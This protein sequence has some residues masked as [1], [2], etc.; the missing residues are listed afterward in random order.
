VIEK[1]KFPLLKEYRINKI[2][3]CLEC[4]EKYPYNRFMQKKCVI[5]KYNVKDNKP[6]ERLEKSIFRGMVLTS[7]RILGFIYGESNFLRLSSNGQLLLEG[8]RKNSNIF[9]YIKQKLILE[10]DEEKFGFLSFFLNNFKV[11]ELKKFL[12]FFYPK[13]NAISIKQKKERIMKWL[14]ILKQVKLIYY[15]EEKIYL[16]EQNYYFMISYINSKINTEIFKENFFKAY[17]FLRNEFGN[18]VEIESLRKN[19]SL[20]LLK[21]ENIIL[22]EKMFDELLRQIPLTTDRYLISLGKPM[23][24]SEKLF[25]YKGNYYKTLIIKPISGS[26]EK[27][28]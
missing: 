11:I 7:L 21:Y 19:T 4:F 22:T 26:C 12:N 2:V 16:N 24:A 23:G 10:I 18:V 28:G 27:N 17:G 1:N 5:G 15:N 3:Q 25:K 9:T 6:F 20:R 13:I 8:K 14:S